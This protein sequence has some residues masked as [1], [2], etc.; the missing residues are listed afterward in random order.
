MKRLFFRGVFAAAFLILSAALSGGMVYA[1]GKRDA[2]K[3]PEPLSGPGLYERAGPGTLVEITGRVRLVG[4]EPFP[5]LVITDGDNHDWYI[6]REDSAALR[7]FE[8]Q[9]VTVR[10]LVYREEMILAN[11][12]RLEDR[13]VL[14]AVVVVE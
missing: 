13:L 1:G 14:S 10:G 4:S 5:E 3:Q 6:A 8:Q 7:K 2:P 9:T 11:G 12:K